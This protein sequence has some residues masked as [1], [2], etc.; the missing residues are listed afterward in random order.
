[1]PHARRRC[2]RFARQERRI[3]DQVITARLL[4]GV[5][6][7]PDEPASDGKGDRLRLEVRGSYEILVFVV[8]VS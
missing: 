6:R 3:G 8:H 7:L 4:P 1:V 2:D 5:Q